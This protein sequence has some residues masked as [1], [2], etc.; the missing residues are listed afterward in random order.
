VSGFPLQ[1]SFNS[2]SYRKSFIG[3]QSPATRCFSAS[4]FG[5][6]RGLLTGIFDVDNL[7]DY[8]RGI[9]L[10]DA[11]NLLRDQKHIYNMALADAYGNATDCKK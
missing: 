5:K 10:D 4:E 2:V 9:S 1:L 3:R 11:A 8:S 6:A 7:K